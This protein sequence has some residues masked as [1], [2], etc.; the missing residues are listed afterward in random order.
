M[1]GQRG[2]RVFGTDS[3]CHQLDGP[4]HRN[5]GYSGRFDA[6]SASLRRCNRHQDNPGRCQGA[7]LPAAGPA[8]LRRPDGRHGQH[9]GS[10]HSLRHRGPRPLQLRLRRSFPEELGAIGRRIRGRLITPGTKTVRVTV[11]DANGDTATATFDW[12]VTGAAILPPAGINVR[13]DWGRLILCERSRQCDAPHSLGD[14]LHQ[15]PHHQLG[16]PWPHSRGCSHSSLIIP[17]AY[18]TKTTWP[19]SFMG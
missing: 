5:P 15:G 19:L 10:D 8:C 18:T 7:N 14:K 1:D 9:R 6:H 3:P 4:E 13:I 17:M 12:T 16:R 11:T 2:R